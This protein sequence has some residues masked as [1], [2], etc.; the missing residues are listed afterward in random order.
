MRIAATTIALTGAPALAAS[1]PGA[2]L[3]ASPSA[4][5]SIV[6][7]S[8]PTS[9]P[10]GAGSDAYVLVVRNDGGAPT[11]GEA[12]HIADTL[13]AGVHATRVIVSGEA[14][15]GGLEYKPTCP[16]EEAGL[17]TGTVT[18]T[19]GEGAKAL[20]VLPGAVIV[21]TVSVSV[22]A[23]GGALE[24]N[25]GTV[26]GGGAPS[27][28]S[29]DV[30]TIG[31]DPA[32]FGVSLFDLV[33]LGNGGEADTQAGSHP[34]ELTTTLAFDVA[35]REPPHQNGGLER[36]LAA[37]AAKDV[38]ITLPPGLVGNPEAVPRC[39]QQA[40]LEAE[41]LN[42]PLDTQVGTV[43]P[44]FFGSFP[45]SSFPVYDVVPPPGEPAELGFS[46]G[47]GHVPLFL[48]VRPEGSGEY[49]LTASISDIPEAGP[50][51]GVILTLWGVPAA[52]SH[53]LEREG[54]LGGGDAEEPTESC[55]P[56]VVE[57]GGEQKVVGCPSGAPTKPFLT[58]PSDCQSP[59]LGVEVEDDSWEQP[60]LQLESF[61]S[62]PLLADAITGC[63]QLG[64]V[65]T[66]SLD[67]ETTQ[68]GAPSG[69]TIDVHVP[70]SEAPQAL[71]TPELHRAQVTLPAG[72]ALSASVANGLQACSPGQFEAGSTAPAGCPPASRIGTV[73]ISTPM[74]SSPL[75]G[76]LYVG[77]PQCAPCDAADA[78][79]GRLLRLDAQ[80]QGFLQDGEH[81]EG[82]WQAGVTVKL[83][84]SGSI[85]QATGQLTASFQ[86]VPELPFED[87][88]L[89]LD[90]GANAPLANAP[91]S[92]ATSSNATSSNAPSANATSAGAQTCVGSLTATSRL[93]PYSSETPAEPSSEPFALSGCAPPRFAPTFVAG[94]TNNQA[95]ASSPLTVTLS[96]T[97]QDE[98]MQAL[99]VT[100]AP[101][102]L[103]LLS[104][105]TP[106]PAAQAQAQACG[107]QSEVGT[108]T[109]GAG[110][111]AA[112]VFL[113]GTVYLTGAYEGAPYGLSVVV[114]AI[115]GPFDLGTLVIGARVTVNPITA[116]L[117]IASDQLPQSLD[118][119]PLQ[120]KT[121]ALDIDR[122]GFV[123]NPTD[124][125]ALEIDGVA[126]SMGGAS[127]QLS[128]HFQAANCATLAFKPKL[129]ALVHAHT[130]KAAG[131]HLHVR[132][133]SAHGQA[134]IAQ[135]KLDLPAG[136]V[137]RLSTLQQACAQAVFQASPA[138]CPRA[139]VVGHA[140][141]LTPLV[142]QPLN[143]SVYVISRAGA[144][145]PVL[146]LVL[147][148]ER[149]TLDV[150]GQ[151][152]VKGGVA[153]AIFRSLPDV[154]FSELDLMLE[155][156][157]HSL[158]T[159]NLPAKD[160]G[161]LCGRRLAL[162]AEITGQNGAV[163]KHTTVIS[164]SGCASPTRAPRKTGAR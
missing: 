133:I 112:P 107:P 90:G 45:T 55:S 50:L 85:D 164:L 29:S 92:N 145:P 93:T 26:S 113:N 8:E 94:T 158:L 13:P 49:A 30:V 141:V 78:Q 41:K 161:N 37:A 86:Q 71:A 91:S 16:E 147:S 155:A 149:L 81:P 80:V 120:L 111:G 43:K 20:P 73:K 3:A 148:G 25:V 39:S 42:C 106:C 35:G 139:S 101:G 129:T 121:L 143:G 152:S 64:F 137:P 162:P 150:L 127:A 53:D 99:D 88:Q 56:R 15:A 14:V 163:V 104:S 61:P 79:E 117:S 10:A 69:Y 51:Q 58:L 1:E 130:S 105:V 70:Q 54:T 23:G 9:F 95:G 100:L 89:T 83:E 126:T 68:A 46:V 159:A 119:I 28:S 48:H 136:I 116:A 34:S 131:V 67:P 27:A 109:V 66:L 132:I 153:T 96:R 6:S 62:Q 98:Q 134:N 87:L 154:P 115:A 82:R 144:A 76:P 77:T 52:S 24:A 135:L 57:E 128:S 19:Y 118:G 59:Q 22:P 63:E 7:E 12:V 65:P 125:R 72:V 146:A 97:D 138:G 5:W 108:A 17:F 160:R 102:L 31:S 124:C 151:T 11:N 36:S 103:G 32:A 33:A 4:H 110:P 38:D 21:M 74:F 84:G 47:S 44:F 142:R 18:C 60:A 140:T 156:G 75:E 122:P 2:A 114:P 157:P 40:F 123:V